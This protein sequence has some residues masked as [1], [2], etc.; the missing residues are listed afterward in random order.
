MQKLLRESC[1]KRNRQVC[2]TKSAAEQ[3]RIDVLEF[4]MLDKILF[5][6][7]SAL[8]ALTLSPIIAGIAVWAGA[9]AGMT[10]GALIILFGSTTAGVFAALMTL[11]GLAANLFFSSSK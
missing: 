7:L 9:F 5:F 2:A 11:A 10:G 8:A 3:C 1:H 6:I 4:S